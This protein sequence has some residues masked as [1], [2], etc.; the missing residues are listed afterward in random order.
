MFCEV[1]VGFI[2][3]PIFE[4]CFG[5]RM[6]VYEMREGSFGRRYVA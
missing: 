4:V 6:E 5:Q 1:E 2:E 3:R